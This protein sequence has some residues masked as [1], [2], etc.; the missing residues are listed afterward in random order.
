MEYKTYKNLA[1]KSSKVLKECYS[2]FSLLRNLNDREKHLSKEKVDNINGKSGDYDCPERLFQNR[3][4]K[5]SRSII[6]LSTV[7]R[8]SLEFDQLKTFYGGLCINI[9]NED[10]F[11]DDEY[12]HKALEVLGS[13]GHISSIISFIPDGD[14]GA[15]VPRESYRKLKKLESEGKLNFKLTPISKNENFTARVASLQGLEKWSIKRMGSGLR[16][17]RY[18]SQNL[19]ANE[20]WK[21]NFFVN[22]QGAKTDDDDTINIPSVE[23]NPGGK[24]IPLLMSN[25]FIPAI[26]YSNYLVMY[27]IDISML[28]LMF[29]CFDITNYID[30][31]NLNNLKN[32]AKQYLESRDY[33]DGNLYHHITNHDSMI[34]ENDRLVDPISVTPIKFKYFTLPDKEDN[35]PQVCHYEPVS[36]YRIRFDK[37]NKFILTANRPHNIF[38]M[39]K[40]SNALQQ[41][42][43]LEEYYENEEKRV[44]LRKAAFETRNHQRSI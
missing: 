44:K 14:P 37:K 19:G 22:I 4:R 10:F 24:P 31:A 20:T 27:D 33:D 40:H 43:T 11:I 8:N 21:G 26:D 17:C 34:F 12:L 42:Q 39:T 28:Y 29:H 35:C 5:S 1:E 2:F 32:I 41:D 30:K 18:T 7:R 16:D 25:G 3:T 15:R 38:W 13:N 23:Y 9:S 6:R 36:D